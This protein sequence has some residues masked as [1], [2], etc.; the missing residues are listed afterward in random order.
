MAGLMSGTLRYIISKALIAELA[1]QLKISPGSHAYLSQRVFFSWPDF[2]NTLSN[3]DRE[4]HCN[5][6]GCYKDP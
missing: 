1:G 4:G 6:V 3:V 5:E 2:E